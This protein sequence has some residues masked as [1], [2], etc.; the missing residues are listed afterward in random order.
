M[1]I[2]TDIQCIHGRHD[3]ARMDEIQR[4]I[5]LIINIIIYGLDTEAALSLFFFF[6]EYKLEINPKPLMAFYRLVALI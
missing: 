4:K 5:K 6:S 2:S 3:K 1:I